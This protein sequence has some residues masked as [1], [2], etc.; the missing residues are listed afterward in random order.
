MLGEWYIIYLIYFYLIKESFWWCPSLRNIINRILLRVN[1]CSIMILLPVFFLVLTVQWK[2]GK[3][4]I[5]VSV[6][7]YLVS[8]CCVITIWTTQMNWK[9]ITCYMPGI[10]NLRSPLSSVSLFD[11]LLCKLWELSVLS[12]KETFL[13]LCWTLE[14]Q[15]IF[16]SPSVLSSLADSRVTTELLKISVSWSRARIS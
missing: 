13:W 9:R 14:N 8:P 1:I 16:Y 4:F 7:G 5:L 11:H 15:N 6:E 2:I 12:S 3:L 10:I